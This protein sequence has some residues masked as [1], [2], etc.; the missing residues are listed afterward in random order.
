[1]TLPLRT[2]VLGGVRS[3][4]SAFAE[5]LASRSE[6][7]CY[8]A[9]GRHDAADSD[10][11]ARIEAHRLRRPPDWVTV[12]SASGLPLALSELC[13]GVTLVDDLGTW[14]TGTI[15]DRDA[16]ELPRGSIAPDSDALVNAVTHRTD[17]VVLVSPEVGWGVVPHTRSGRLFQ[18][19]MGTLNR[20]LATVCDSVVLVVAGLP[21]AL[22]GSGNWAGDP[23]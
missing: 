21:L 23:S 9:T 10:W 5:A 19:E 8:I 15:D 11:E 13:D 17:P 1:M 12:E 16:W 4:K 3:G 20:R 22:K 7:V 6:R 14:L 18:D 2:L